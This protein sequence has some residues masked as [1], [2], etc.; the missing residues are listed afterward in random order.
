MNRGRSAISRLPTRHSRSNE[1]LL[2]AAVLAAVAASAPAQL[3]IPR[4]MRTQVI[5]IDIPDPIEFEASSGGTSS[6]ADAAALLSSAKNPVM[7]VASQATLFDARNGSPLGSTARYV[8]AHAPC[9][10]LVVPAGG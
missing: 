4:D 3:N 6:V 10:V 7:I 9:P 1:A 2:T 5:D 8:V